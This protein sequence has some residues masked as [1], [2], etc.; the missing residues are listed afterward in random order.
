MDETSTKIP[1]DS[2]RQTLS[3]SEKEF[4]WKFANEIK[5]TA[6]SKEISKF[7]I[8]N[9]FKLIHYVTQSARDLCRADVATEETAV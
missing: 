6:R 9:K 7:S 2:W 4:A 5:N 8:M 1:N 3:D